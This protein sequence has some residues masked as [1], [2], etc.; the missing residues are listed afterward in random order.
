MVRRSDRIMIGRI[1]L[2][3]AAGPAHLQ[4]ISPG[5][6][7]F[8]FEV[9]EPFRRQGF[10]REASL[11][12]MYWATARHGVT[13]FVLT[14]RADNLPSQA[15]AAQLGFTRIG[16][17]VDEIDGLEDILELQIDKRPNGGLAIE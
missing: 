10:A 12:L 17:H 3:E 16:E 1:R 8:G 6:A 11:A 2:H 4:D 5:A 13:R 7:E 9:F 15:L 14:I